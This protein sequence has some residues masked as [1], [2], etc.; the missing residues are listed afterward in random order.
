M[1][2][3]EIRDILRF[4]N[5]FFSE[6][7]QFLDIKKLSSENTKTAEFYKILTGTTIQEDKEAANLIYG[8]AKPNA[9]FMSLKSQF[10]SRTLN[11]ITH[12]DLSHPKISHVTKA[13]FISY[14]NLFII[15]ALLRMDRRRAAMPLVR[16][17]L[18]ITEKYELY[19]VAVELLE[20]LR[21]YALLM[22]EKTNYE[23]IVKSLDRNLNLLCSESKVRTL[24]QRLQIHSA[25][26]IHIKDELLPQALESVK[27][28]EK[29]LLTN[30]SYANRMA[31]FRLQYMYYQYAGS[32]LDSIA[33]CENAIEYMNTKQHLTSPIR[34]GEFKL[35]ILE[36]YT[37]AQDYENGKQ[38]ATDCANY[39]PADS[40]P[41]LQYKE[42]YFLLLMVQS[43]FDEAQIIYD[44]VLGNI[45]LRSQLAAIAERW[46]IYK[47]YLDY[48]AELDKRRR[49]YPLRQKRYQKRMKEYPTYSKD[50][51]G[52]NVSLLILNI[53]LLLEGNKIDKIED[54]SE[55]LSTYGYSH[56]R[57]KFSSQSSI[58]FK[59]IRIMVENDYNYEIIIKKTARLERKLA[60]TKPSRFEIAETVMIF[61]PMMMWL[62]MKNA[63]KKSKR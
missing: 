55:A 31:Y 10:I 6:E 32:T 28:I 22:G 23:K 53:L 52:L 13:V 41:W 57:S 2:I 30:D 5:D 43:K 33:A 60:V 45:R 47:L 51:N 20:Q 29:E 37:I 62:R 15:S 1:K 44:E 12:I 4:I 63:L 48:G 14:K 58:L 8:T 9:N 59:M 46:E 34:I 39:I 27:E 42:Q 11:T 40:S 24:L 18:I 16:K 25:I 36:N 7:N 17:T 3:E 38:A 56:L 54:Q 26:S 35:R 61:P 49:A 19:H 50:K 21:N